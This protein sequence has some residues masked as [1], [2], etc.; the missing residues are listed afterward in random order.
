VLLLTRPISP[1]AGRQRRLKA[2]LHASELIFIERVARD[3]RHRQ[4]FPPVH[5]AIRTWRIFI[6][7]RLYGFMICREAF[8]NVAR[9]DFPPN[10]GFGPVE[11]ADVGL[12]P[13][14]GGRLGASNLRRT[15]DKLFHIHDHSAWNPGEQCRDSH[16]RSIC[17]RKTEIA[18][19]YRLLAP[20]WPNS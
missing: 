14:S 19:R 9:F 2:A 11:T 16:G 4:F 12:P 17:G 6:F 20:T 13:G 8:S 10:A 5:P 18:A 1:G 3:W 15:L 7:Y